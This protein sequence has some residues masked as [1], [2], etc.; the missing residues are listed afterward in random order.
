MAFA[1]SNISGADFEQLF[2][3]PSPG[4]RNYGE[5]AAF[6]LGQVAEG[7]DGSV[8]VYCQFG[9]GG[10]T[11]S[12][13][14]CKITEA[15]E[16]LMLSTSNDTFGDKVGV[17][18]CG[19][20]VEDD[21]AWLQVYGVS[22]AIRVSASAAENVALGTTATAGELDDAGGLVVNGVIITTTNG[23]AAAVQPGLLNWPTITATAG[24]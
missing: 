11:G 10:L 3:P 9:T 6:D 15:F 19:V 5:Q 20:A 14:V 7:S 22:P 23:G 21:Y 8:W 17:P 16:A 2:H 4:D 18:Q 24:P 13:Y 12:G 1:T